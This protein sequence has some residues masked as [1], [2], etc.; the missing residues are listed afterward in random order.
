M[1][2]QVSFALPYISHMYVFSIL[3]FVIT[4][5]KSGAINTGIDSILV[6]E[7]GVHRH[8]LRDPNG[9]DDRSPADLPDFES[10]ER[11]S[12][13]TTPL[14]MKVTDLCDKEGIGRPYFIL[15]SFE[16]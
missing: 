3:F 9:K 8:E 16:P 2:S 1:I 11:F 5:A 10:K 13:S 12:A 6:T 7:H 14:L 15:R 4:L